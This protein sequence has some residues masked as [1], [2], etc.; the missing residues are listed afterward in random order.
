M[1]KTIVFILIALLLSGC[2][3]HVT[4]QIAKTRSIP[5]VPVLDEVDINAPDPESRSLKGGFDQTTTRSAT[6]SREFT[7][8][9]AF[10]DYVEELLNTDIPEDA[11]YPPVKDALGEWMFALICKKETAGF[12]MN[13]LGYTDIAFGKGNSTLIIDLHPYL[14]EYQGEII[15]ETDESAGYTS[16]EGGKSSDGGIWL[17]DSDSLAIHLLEY[18]DYQGQEYIIA[19]MWI[20]DTN[21]GDMLFF[22]GQE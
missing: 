22:R 15:E 5:A 21:F 6:I 7:D 1:K 18:F 8:F 19:R 9:S 12:D 16:F 14:M 4:T 13:E 10:F 2:T 11:Y 3:Q 17:E 20:N